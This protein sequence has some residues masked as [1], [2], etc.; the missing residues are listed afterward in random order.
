M[1]GR[2]IGINVPQESFGFNGPD[3]Q[4]GG[5]GGGGFDMNALMQLLG[6]GDGGGGGG[7]GLE[8]LTGLS[9]FLAGPFGG[10]ATMGLG[11]LIG[12]IG[13]LIGGDGG[14]GNRLRTAQGSAQGLANSEI[15]QGQLLQLMS[16]F[17]KSQGPRLNKL[18]GEAA[19]RVGLDSGIGQA[20]ALNRLQDDRASFGTQSLLAAIQRVS[21]DRR[22]GARLQAGLV[23]A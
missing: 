2:G 1:A 21:Q 5:G 9:G 6:G 12:G 20:F 18:F 19:S 17:D 3:F 11:G 15:D 7:F 14:R 10:L 16:L 13:S 4:F 22:V 23:N 8:K